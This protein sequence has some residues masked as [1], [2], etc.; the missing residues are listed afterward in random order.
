MFAYA[1][2]TRKNNIKSTPDLGR[3]SISTNCFILNILAPAELVV[4]A[5]R[6]SGSR[7]NV[8]NMDT[9][10]SPAAKNPGTS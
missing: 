8:R 3:R 7:I 1:K 9:N 4:D 10:D 5:V 6:D 2:V